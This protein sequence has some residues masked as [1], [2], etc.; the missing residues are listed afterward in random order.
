MTAASPRRPGR[1]PAAQTD[2]PA[3]DEVLRRGL[4]A[5][6]Q[7]GYDGTTVRELSR[8]LGV[9]HSF[10]GDR[11]GSKAGLWRAVVDQAELPVVAR[12]SAILAADYPDDADRLRDGIG[13]FFAAVAEAPEIARLISWELPSD[14]ERLHYLAERHLAPV[15]AG[16]R[17]LYTRLVAA[18]RARDIPFEVV[19]LAVLA[20]A[21]SPQRLPLVRL[22]DGGDAGTAENLTGALSAIVLDG[23]IVG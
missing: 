8:L 19:L 11:Y 20:L 9:S 12:I 5:F 21:G 4:S 10:I 18:G 23:L 15:V 7:L 1:P 3:D 6:A 17:P 13:A 2:V 14:S 22:V 16:L